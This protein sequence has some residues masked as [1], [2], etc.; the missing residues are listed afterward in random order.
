M[1]RVTRKKTPKLDDCPCAGRHLEKFIQPAV[2]SA[3]AA[4]PLHGYLLVQRLGK[5]PM[6]QAQSPDSTGVYRFLNAMEDRG[7]VVASWDVSQSGPARKLFRLTAEGK[8]CL[9]QWVTTLERYYSHFGQMLH[10]LRR[11]TGTTPAKPCRCR[12]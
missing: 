6:F 5:M 4:E 10:I 2:L 9:K 8:R 12:K 3:L 1:A 11:A 7:L